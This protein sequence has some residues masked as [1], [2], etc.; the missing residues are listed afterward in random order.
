[1]DIGGRDSN[2]ESKRE[3]S[4]ASVEST[5]ELGF[6]RGDGQAW[7]RLRNRRQMSEDQGENLGS[8]CRPL[9]GE[10]WW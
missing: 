2:K 6:K 9:I 8:R 7:G 5:N 10:V 4:E 1:L 3:I